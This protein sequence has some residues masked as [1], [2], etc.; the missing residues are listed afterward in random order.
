MKPNYFNDTIKYA[1]IQ[2]IAENK[3][4]GNQTLRM[5]V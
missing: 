3:K 5:K 2:R 4:D 1:E